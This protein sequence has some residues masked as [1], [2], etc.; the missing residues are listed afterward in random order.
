MH[1]APLGENEI[2]LTRTNLNWE[3]PPFSYPNEALDAWEA[4]SNNSK[5]IYN[6]WT[7]NINKSDLK[8]NFYDALNLSLSEKLFSELK[9]LSEEIKKEKPKNATRKSSQQALEI[10]NKNTD[11]LI[12]GSADL[13]GSN[14]TL[15]K[16]MEVI[17]S[18]NFEGN[19]I[20][21][22]VRE[23]AMASI[24]NGISLLSLIHI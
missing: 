6:N 11:L 8:K 21:Y 18:D 16:E 20:H 23:H 10:I 4:I 17:S 22:G 13:T 19:Y 5:E 12:G 7:D 1:G 9:S 14:L 3:Y 2:K 24:M 15:T